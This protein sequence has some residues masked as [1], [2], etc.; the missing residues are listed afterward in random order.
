MKKFKRFIIWGAKLDTKHTHSFIHEALYK[1]AIFMGLDVFWLDNRDN[2]DE[3]F[4][5][6]SIVVT[7][8]W[9]VFDNLISKNISNKMPLNKTACYIVHYLGNL[10]EV[11]G[12]PGASMYLDRVG[13][14]IDFRFTAKFGWGANGVPDK[15]YKYSLNQKNLFKFNEVSYYEKG[16]L[17]DNFYSIWATD[18][19]PGEFNFNAIDSNKE[20]RAFFCGTI[21]EYNFEMFKPFIDRC[22]NS[23]IPFIF[24]SPTNIALPTEEIRKYV[25]TSLFPLDLRPRNHLA[26]GY[27]A[28][29]PIKNV[30]YGALGMTNSLTIYEFFDGDIAYHGNPD[31][32]FDVAL[33]MQSDPLTKAKIRRQMIKIKEDHTYVNRVADLIRAAEL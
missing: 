9:L 7:E 32:L 20:N 21:C 28:C 8:Q 17:Y 10:G 5:N 23:K 15:N 13:K 24:N 3:A 30:S 22:K 29:R 4:F 11:E 33:T 25:T 18:L 26:N 16:V 19:L 27:I 12:N 6:N 31:L 1:A 14:L 2:V